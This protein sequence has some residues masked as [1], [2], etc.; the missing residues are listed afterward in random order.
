MLDCLN[1]EIIEEGIP[2]FSV[3]GD[4]VV[5]CVNWEQLE[6]AIRY[7]YKKSLWRN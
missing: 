7:V 2:Y 1:E 3:L 4:E 5:D 6:I